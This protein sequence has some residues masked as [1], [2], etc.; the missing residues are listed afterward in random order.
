MMCGIREILII[1][2][3]V[4]IPHFKKLL[5]DGKNLGLRLEYVI[6]EKPEE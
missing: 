2:T 3:P 4:D 5:G 6:Q 1:S